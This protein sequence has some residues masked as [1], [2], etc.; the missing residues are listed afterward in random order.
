M[1]GLDLARP[2]QEHGKVDAMIHTA[3]CYGRQEENAT[4]VFEANTGFPLRLLEAATFFNTDTILYGSLVIRVARIFLI[5]IKIIQ[6][7][8][9]A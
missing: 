3:T 4:V 5:Y 9:T 7:V 8:V 6:L 1:E 2:F